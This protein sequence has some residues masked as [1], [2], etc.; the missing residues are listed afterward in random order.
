[1]LNCSCQV[2]P[3]EKFLPVCIYVKIS[4]VS[5]TTD[6]CNINV[7]KGKRR[8]SHGIPVIILRARG[9]AG[10]YPFSCLV[11]RGEADCPY[12]GQLGN[13]FLTI[14]FHRIS[15]GDLDN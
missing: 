3:E 15:F 10:N 14:F 11:P 9:M 13:C 8:Q 6:Q 7:Y 12:L 1:M 2:Y 4:C 5:A